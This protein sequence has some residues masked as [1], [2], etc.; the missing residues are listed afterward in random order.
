MENS[1]HLNLPFILPQQ[2][3]KHVT[4]NEALRSLDA[5]IHL[6]VKERTRIIPPEAPIE[7]SRYI[8]P[9]NADGAWSERDF[10]IAAFQDGD[11]AF[12]EPQTGWLA[13]VEAEGQLTL[14]DGTGWSDISS[15]NEQDPNSPSEVGSLSINH[16]FADDINRLALNAPAALFNHDGSD[17]RLIINK[18]DL[19]NV[20]SLVFQSNFSA[21]AELGIIGNNNFAIRVSKNGTTWQTPLSID[22]DLGSV[23]VSSLTM[24]GAVGVDNFFGRASFHPS[25]LPSNLSAADF[26]MSGG[27]N[28]NFIFASNANNNNEGIVF[29]QL[30]NGNFTEQ[31]RLD[32]IAK[33]FG[34]GT[35]NPTT[36]LHVEGPIR[37]GQYTTQNAPSPIQSGVGSMIYVTNE[38]GGPIP[39]FSDGQN[40]RRIND[41]EIISA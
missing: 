4:H 40:W 36:K 11:W 7:G 2:A 22:P 16:A 20:A 17:H 23:Q 26:L 33:R 28:N 3:Q 25:G 9:E 38:T 15:N 32:V 29:G 39:A 24:T 27:V 37:I 19:D 21:R 6:S 1:T 12:Y 41:R 13:W 30:R 31:M 10:F 35:S 8:I 5:I 34:I 18:A 14:W